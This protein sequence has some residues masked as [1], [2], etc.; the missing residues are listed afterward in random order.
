VTQLS[1]KAIP[2][3]LVE[4]VSVERLLLREDLSQQWRETTAEI[5]EARQ[6]ARCRKQLIAERREHR[7]DHHGTA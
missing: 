2:P 5:R 6:H 1:R 4:L 7:E 3:K